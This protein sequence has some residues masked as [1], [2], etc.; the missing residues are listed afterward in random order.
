M[1]SDKDCLSSVSRSYQLPNGDRVRE[2][3]GDEPLEGLQHLLLARIRG[4]GKVPPGMD[5]LGLLAKGLGDALVDL[6]P[7]EEGVCTYNTVCCDVHYA[8]S[9]HCSQVSI[10]LAGLLHLIFCSTSGKSLGMLLGK[11]STIWKEVLVLGPTRSGT[12][13][14][15][16]PPPPHLIDPLRPEFLLVLLRGRVQLFQLLDGQLEGGAC[17][18]LHVTPGERAALAKHILKSIKKQSY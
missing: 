12:R 4:A 10:S 18:L 16:I 9:H 11:H 14:L 17:L 7:E 13:T 8:F 1:R 2:H 3:S 15:L 6:P 5:L